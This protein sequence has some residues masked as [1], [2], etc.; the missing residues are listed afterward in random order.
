MV[1]VLES[2]E[3][4]CPRNVPG[5]PD[6]SNHD[7]TIVHKSQFLQ[8]SASSIC[9]HPI[10][11]QRTDLSSTPCVSPSSS[12]NLECKSNQWPALALEALIH[13]T[14]HL[15]PPPPCSTTSTRIL[16]NNQRRRKL[17][18][19]L[20]KSV[21]SGIE[22]EVRVLF[23]DFEGVEECDSGGWL[24]WFVFGFQRPWCRHGLLGWTR[25]LRFGL[26][27]CCCCCCW[28]RGGLR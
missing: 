16:I 27:W 28:L 1:L 10:C 22:S 8:R 6:T 12:S 14:P 26:G 20:D 15:S 23:V 11:L 21:R 9:M 4:V 5:I 24:W 7:M 3:R 19:S 17:Q 2:T 25:S 13:S 18:I